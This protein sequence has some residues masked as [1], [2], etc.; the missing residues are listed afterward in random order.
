MNTAVLK[1]APVEP[2]IPPLNDNIKKTLACAKSVLD[3]RFSEAAVA[4]GFIPDLCLTE[5]DIQPFTENSVRSYMR[6][7][8]WKSMLRDA[9]APAFVLFGAIAGILAL[10]FWAAAPGWVVVAGAIG[11]GAIAFIALVVTVHVFAHHQTWHIVPISQYDQPVPL[12][13]LQRAVKL[14]ETYAIKMRAHGLS[15]DHV[16][17]PYG[18]ATRYQITFLAYPKASPVNADPFLVWTCNGKRYYIDAWAEPGFNQE[19]VI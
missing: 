8:L 14:E 11:L 3:Y 15:P 5:L 4:R 9:M 13:V 18:T 7:E 2:V 1:R 19:R 16:H 17:D 12:E 6:R 10:L